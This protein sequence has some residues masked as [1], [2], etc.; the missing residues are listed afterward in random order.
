MESAL[1]AADHLSPESILNMHRALMDG[2]NDSEGAGQW[3]DEQVW[4]G[5]SHVS[6]IG[7]D[8]V[9]PH[10]THVPALMDDVMDYARRTDIPALVQVAI[11]HAQFETIHPFTDGNGRTGRALHAMLKHRGVASHVTVP[12]SAGLL[13]DVRNYHDALTAY[14]AGDPDRIITVTAEASFLAI[15]NGTRLAE[16]VVAITESWAS[17]ITA[18]RDSAVWPVLD[19]LARQPVVNAAV[20]ESKLGLDYMR[21]KRALDALEAAASSS[22]WTS[23]RKAAADGRLRCSRL[24]TH[25]RN[26]RDAA[27]AASR[28]LR[29][30]S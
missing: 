14:R 18:R 11:A 20:L 4:I 12:V 26:V 8:F 22:A 9:P 16:D 5:S 27:A 1:A 25:S 30:R 24:W 17:K 3:R 21:Q 7:A 23:S 13:A 10:H 29:R 15:E 28:A 2:T 6:P 19:L